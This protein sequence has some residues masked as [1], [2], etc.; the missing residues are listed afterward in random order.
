MEFSV[1]ANAKSCKVATLLLPN[2]SIQKR[3]CKPIVRHMF[4]QTK[5]LDDTRLVSKCQRSPHNAG[6]MSV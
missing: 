4:H 5:Y 6:D 3:E 1:R 2:R